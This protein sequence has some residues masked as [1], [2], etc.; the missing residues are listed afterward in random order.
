M[1]R[2]IGGRPGSRIVTCFLSMSSDVS[3]SPLSSRRGLVLEHA[4]E[5]SGSFRVIPW[6]RVSVV[7]PPGILPG[8]D[9]VYFLV[10]R[11]TTSRNGG[12]PASDG[13]GPIRASTI[14]FPNDTRRSSATSAS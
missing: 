9:S 1:N 13:S 11:P 12:S 3:Q 4:G 10:N 6:F 14:G 8:L 5:P 7:N 2:P